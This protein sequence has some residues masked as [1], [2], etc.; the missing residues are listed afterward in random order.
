MSILL[1]KTAELHGMQL[2]RRQGIDGQSR[3][4]SVA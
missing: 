3:M 1:P 4:E 2:S